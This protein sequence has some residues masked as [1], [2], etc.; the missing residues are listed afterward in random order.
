MKLC[1]CTFLANFKMRW[2]AQANTLLTLKKT[3]IV[4]VN[5]GGE[6]QENN[7]LF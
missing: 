4:L 3:C 6:T 2:N 7:I 5:F 1:T